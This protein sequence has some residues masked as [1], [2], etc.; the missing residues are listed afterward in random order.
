MKSRLTFAPPDD[1]AFDGADIQKRG[2]HPRSV[3]AVSVSSSIHRSRGGANHRVQ[4]GTGGWG[5]RDDGPTAVEPI[6]SP[7][8][9]SRKRL[10]PPRPPR[11][12]GSFA[13]SGLLTAHRGVHGG[14]SLSRGPEKILLPEIIEIFE[15]P[16]AVTECQEGGDSNCLLGK[17]CPV[18]T[19]WRP[20]NEAVRRALTQVTLAQM[21]GLAPAEAESD[22]GI[23]AAKKSS[24]ANHGNRE[25]LGE[26]KKPVRANGASR[27]SKP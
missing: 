13:R 5:Q 15:G 19:R 18:R 20:I 1:Q 23:G 4:R 25:N 7:A 10:R 8:L 17:K 14:Y 11:L 26:E 16:I 6:A 22:N 27:A 24:P 2:G 21:A 12:S 9:S 3:A